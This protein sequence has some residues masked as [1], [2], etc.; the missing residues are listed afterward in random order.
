[1]TCSKDYIGTHQ[2]S[3]ASKNGPIRK[4]DDLPP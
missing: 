2:C 1:V 4:G 3:G